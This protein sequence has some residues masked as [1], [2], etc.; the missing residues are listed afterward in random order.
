M[1]IFLRFLIVQL[2][3]NRAKHQIY[4]TLLPALIFACLPADMETTIKILH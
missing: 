3:P 1:G 2:V 4:K